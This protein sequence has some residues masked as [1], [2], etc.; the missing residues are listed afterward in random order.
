MQLFRS[1]KYIALIL[2]LLGISS[3]A[4]AAIIAPNFDLKMQVGTTAAY[5]LDATVTPIEDGGKN[6]Y[7]YDAESI[8][9]KRFFKSYYERIVGGS[10]WHW[11]G[12]Y[13]R[14]LPKISK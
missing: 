3:F 5:G 13:M 10:T 6:Y 7:D 14:M 4:S 2:V 9:K 1:S 11:Q 8:S 12:I